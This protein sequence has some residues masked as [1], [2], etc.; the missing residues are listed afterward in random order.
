MIQVVVFY[1]DH[2]LRRIVDYKWKYMFYNS[3][4]KL[5]IYTCKH[6]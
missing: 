2:S 1:N 6:C 3:E 5:I 4:A